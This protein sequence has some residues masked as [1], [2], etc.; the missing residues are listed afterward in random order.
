MKLEVLDTIKDDEESP[1]TWGRGLKLH[2][3]LV[4]FRPELSPPTWGRGL[5]PFL[6]RQ[7][8]PECTVAPHV[9]AWVETSCSAAGS[10]SPWSPPTWGRGLKQRYRWY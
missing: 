5:K 10:T 6:H 7:L 2:M 3:R 9:G 1:P 4:D 8:L